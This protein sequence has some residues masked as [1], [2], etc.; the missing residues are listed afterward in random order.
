MILKDITS[1]PAI[2]DDLRWDLTQ[3]MLDA[4]GPLRFHPTNDM[5]E[6]GVERILREHKEQAGYYFCIHAW[7]DKARLTLIHFLQVGNR[8]V[9]DITG[10]PEKFLIEAIS[11]AKIHIDGYFTINKTIEDMLRFRL[12]VSRKEGSQ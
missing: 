12:M 4:P 9:E 5:T 6:D 1:N 8:E 10:F 2:M 3:K 11:D 7:N